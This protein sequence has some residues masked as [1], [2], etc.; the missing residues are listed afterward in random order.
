VGNAQLLRR[1][2]TAEKC[3]V[4]NA[5]IVIPAGSELVNVICELAGVLPLAKKGPESVV[6]PSNRG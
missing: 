4:N 5:K 2:E 3:L 1:L 6:A